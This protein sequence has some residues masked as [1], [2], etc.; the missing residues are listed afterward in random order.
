M[1]LKLQQME[2][3][4]I[5][6]LQML[7]NKIQHVSLMMLVEYLLILEYNEKFYNRIKYRLKEKGGSLS[8]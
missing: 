2:L 4:E 1:Y 3:F 7:L 8:I 6:Q 5:L